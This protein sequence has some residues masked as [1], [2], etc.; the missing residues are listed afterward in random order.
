M[1]NSC[2]YWRGHITTNGGYDVPC[3]QQLAA[4]RY[5]HAWHTSSHAVAWAD[6]LQSSTKNDDLLPLPSFESESVCCSVLRCAS[7]YMHARV[8]L[9]PR[10]IAGRSHNLSL[11]LISPITLKQPLL[12]LCH[13]SQ[14]PLLLLQVLHHLVA[15]TDVMPALY[16]RRAGV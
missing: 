13:A 10:L 15:C 3:L 9:C 14:A 7:A 8:W 16:W 12:L 2:G 6:S 4:A 11:H 1:S 5:K